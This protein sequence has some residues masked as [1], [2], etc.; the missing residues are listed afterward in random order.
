MTDKQWWRSRVS[1]DYSLPGKKNLNNKMKS[2]SKMNPLTCDETNE[3]LM[4]F[5]A[6]KKPIIIILSRN[7]KKNFNIK[8]NISEVNMKRFCSI[9]NQ[10]LSCLE[11]WNTKWVD[12]IWQ[13]KK[14]LPTLSIKR[15]MIL[16]MRMLGSEKTI[17]FS[18]SN[19]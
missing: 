14:N 18:I 17:R 15:K 19:N 5:P 8:K 10:T 13:R 2:K 12:L 4:R 1:W 11:T 3:Q 9:E 7:W 16:M 6:N